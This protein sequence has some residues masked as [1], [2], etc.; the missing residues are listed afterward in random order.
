MKRYKMEPELMM[1]SVEIKSV[2]SP[3]G[4]WVKWE[5]VDDL[6]YIN[7][8]SKESNRWLV[9][10]HAKEIKRLKAT[11]DEEI[12]DLVGK[13]VR[14]SSIIDAS[15]LGSIEAVECN[16]E[17]SAKGCDYGYWYRIGPY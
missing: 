17:D 13:S 3:H 14:E 4:Q 2:E 12:K 11:H 10:E 9:V 15:V 16:C 1:Y 5:D 7:T 8:C 6:K